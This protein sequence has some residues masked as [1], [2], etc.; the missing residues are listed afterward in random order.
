MFHLHYSCLRMK[1][2]FFSSNFVKGPLLSGVPLLLFLGLNREVHCKRLML[3]SGSHYFQGVIFRSLQYFENFSTCWL[4]EDNVTA[5]YSM[6]KFVFCLQIIVPLP[7][8]DHSEVFFI[9]LLFN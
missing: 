8:V 5:I 7:A 4:I 1:K 9:F 6:N 2:T 3:L